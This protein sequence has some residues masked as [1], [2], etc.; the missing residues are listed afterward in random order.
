M[1]LT[2]LKNIAHFSKRM[3]G[4]DFTDVFLE[5]EWQEDKSRVAHTVIPT[6]E[7]QKQKISGL[8]SSS[9]T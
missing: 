4:L 3:C 6:L 1:T 9:V 7:R 2:N 5:S 8:Q